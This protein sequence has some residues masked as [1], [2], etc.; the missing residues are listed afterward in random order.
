MEKPVFT[1]KPEVTYRQAATINS[2]L[3]D[4]VDFTIEEEKKRLHELM[5]NK[6]VE[7]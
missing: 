3:D 4:L 6:E 5:K 1:G 2:R 7:K